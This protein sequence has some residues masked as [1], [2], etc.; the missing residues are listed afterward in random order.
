MSGFI[1]KINNIVRYI[2]VKNMPDGD[3]VY[4]G[5]SRGF[6][7]AYKEFCEAYFN[8]E[9]VAGKIAKALRKTVK[10]YGNPPIQLVLNTVE[11]VTSQLIRGMSI[12]YVQEGYI[13]D[14]SAR[15]SM[16]HRRGMPLAVDAC[17]ACVR[18]VAEARDHNMTKVVVIRE[19]VNRVLDAD[20]FEHLPLLSHHH[21]VHPEVLEQRL[22]QIRP[23]LDLEIERIVAQ[24]AKA[25]RVDRLRKTSKERKAE[26]DFSQMDIAM[27]GNWQGGYE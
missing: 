2:G 6:A 14:Q 7:G 26:L 11:G 25:E 13:I 16:G 10:Q 5:V 27:P 8:N 3:V 21:N 23:Y 22:H 24:I 1:R 18:Q 12:D 15:E 19:Y 4:H 20:F 17:K 9:Q